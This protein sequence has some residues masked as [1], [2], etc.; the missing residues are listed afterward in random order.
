M[1][2][3]FLALGAFDFQ[4]GE[5]GGAGYG[6]RPDSQPPGV[7]AAQALLGFCPMKRYGAGFEGL[8]PVAGA[9]NP[10]SL[11]ESGTYNGA[12]KGVDR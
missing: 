11:R 8:V 7:P 4:A 2:R 6:T 12:R 1:S 5:R 3:G 10:N 9:G